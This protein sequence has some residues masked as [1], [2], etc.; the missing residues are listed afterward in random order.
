MNKNSLY[1]TENIAKRLLQCKE[2]TKHDNAENKEAWTLA[3]SFIELEQSFHV[4]SNKLLPRLIS[5]NL[6]EA[7]ISDLLLE[8]GEEFRHILYHIHD[9]Q[10]YRY[11]P[12]L[13]LD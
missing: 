9:P 7:E 11:L 3:H 10:Y 8:I 2:V 12:S 1:T 4:F 5:Q 13:N 6:N